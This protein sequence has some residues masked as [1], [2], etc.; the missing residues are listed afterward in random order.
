LIS[1]LEA[2]APPGL[3]DRRTA[4]PRQGQVA[5]GPAHAEALSAMQRQETGVV[6]LLD[7]ALSCWWV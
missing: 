6:R 3:G 4:F 1:E 2:A 5:D 7:S